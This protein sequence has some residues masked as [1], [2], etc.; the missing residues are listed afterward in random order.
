[1]LAND[2]FRRLGPPVRAETRLICFPHAGGAASSYVRL[3]RVLSPAVEVLAVQYPGRQDRRH[4]QAVTDLHELAD[5]IADAFAA[6]TDQ[7]YAFFGHS[8]G[9]VL[10]YETA[11]RLD[12]HG[13]P[14]PQRLFLSGRGAPSRGSQRS[15]R[16]SGDAALLA[17]I[18]RLGGRGSATLD[19][20]ELLALAMPA[21]RADYQALRGYT[22]VPGSPLRCPITVLVGDSDPVVVRD[23]AAAWDAHSAAP[24]ELRVFSGGHFYLEDELEGVAKVVLAGLDIRS[25]EAEFT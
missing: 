20:P 18:R 5:R 23:D 22:C 16:L 4:E 3:S 7:S 19:D 25:P 8:M 10:A 6:H 11:R 24:T 2:W 14:G 1:M 12:H 15:D 21:I 13:A 9:A 17:E